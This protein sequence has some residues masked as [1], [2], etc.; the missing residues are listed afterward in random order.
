LAAHVKH[1]QLHLNLLRFCQPHTTP[2][3]F[4]THVGWFRCSF[5]TF[6]GSQ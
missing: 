6:R 2:S 4:K 3:V 1:H 5:K